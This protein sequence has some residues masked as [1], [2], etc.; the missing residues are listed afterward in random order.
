MSNKILPD[1]VS[2]CYNDECLLRDKC[3]RFIHRKNVSGN[4]ILVSAFAPNENGKCE[5]LIIDEDL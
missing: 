2:R 1:D 3:L 4:I 5:N